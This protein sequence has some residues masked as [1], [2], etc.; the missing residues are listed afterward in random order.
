MPA[1]DAV[2][3]RLAAP[4]HAVQVAAHDRTAVARPRSLTTPSVSGGPPRRVAGVGVDDLLERG[5]VV[6]VVGPHHRGEAQVP[7]GPGAVA[8]LQPAQ[9]DAVLRVVVD[10]LDVERGDELLLG[11]GEATG[12][13][14][15]ARQRL[16]HRA[17]G[18]LELARLLERDHGRV[19]VAV[20][21]Q[22]HALG[23]GGV[24]V[25]VA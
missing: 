13:E 9:P 23:E 5:P 4:H 7:A 22:P 18:R 14:V 12:A 10:R 19:R 3:R 25:V 20:G 17:L 2:D 21:E 1:A 8:G 24:C 15:G 6:G 11:R 16:A